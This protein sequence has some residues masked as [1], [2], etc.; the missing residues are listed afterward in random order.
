[1]VPL[2]ILKVKTFS[3]SSLTLFVLG[4]GLTSG[5]LIIT[6]LLT[7]VMEQSELKAGLIVST[8]ALSSMVTSVFSG[9]LL[10][11]LGGRWFSVIGMSALTVTTYL[12]GTIRYDSPISRIILLLCITGLAIG[13]VMGPAMGSSIREIPEDKI[14]IA[15]GVVNMMR[16]VGQALG[17]AIL[18]T[19]LSSNITS[20]MDTSKQEA[21]SIIEKSR[22]LDEAAKQEVIK[23]V[24]AGNVSGKSSNNQILDAIDVKEREILSKTPEQ[25]KS[26]VKKSFEIQKKEILHLRSKIT[27][28]YNNNISDAFDYTFQV[29]GWIVSIGI[30]FAIF[31]DISPARLRREKSQGTF[32]DAHY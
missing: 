21:I 22:I 26:K 15:S 1:M 9:K 24:K 20:N 12:Y 32:H 10:D 3:F 23:S 11:K 5:T 28:V 18:A 6:L 7:T 4:L 30:V 25:Y 19:I 2:K 14:G 8:L 31:S 17:I 29:A 13:L 27:E 16:S